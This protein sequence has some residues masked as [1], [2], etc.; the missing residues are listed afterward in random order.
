MT[1]TS[2]SPREI[3]NGNGSATVFSF[4]FVVNQASDLVVTL[5]DANANETVLTEGTGTTNYSV[6]VSSYPGTGSVTYPATLGTKLAAN[7]Q[8]VIQRVVDLDQETDLVNQGAWRPEQV[9][10]TFDYSRMVDLQQQDELDRALKAPASTP[11]GTTYTLPAPESLA[12]FRWNETATDLEAAQTSDLVTTANFSN[13]TVDA[14]AD[15]VDYTAGTTTQI[16]LQF[17]PWLDCKYA[18]LL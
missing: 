5:V 13:F 18:G 7:Q 12:L 4:T 8:L 10:N 3:K 16:A 15:G 17:G 6:S 11:L 1:I 2:T 14:F 9:E